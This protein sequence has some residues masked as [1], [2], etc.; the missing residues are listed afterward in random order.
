MAGTGGDGEGGRGE[1]GSAN[2]REIPDL[3]NCEIEKLS[4]LGWDRFM[5]GFSPP[6]L[7]RIRVA[8]RRHMAR[9]TLLRSSPEG[10]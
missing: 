5:N 6:V 4:M 9:P 10:F 8:V 3:I 2:L 1:G 7:T